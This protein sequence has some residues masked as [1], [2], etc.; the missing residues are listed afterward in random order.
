MVQ[1]R[2]IFAAI[3]VHFC[4]GS[5]IAFVMK[6]VNGPAPSVPSPPVRPVDFY[7]ISERW[8]NRM[9]EQ[10]KTVQLNEEKKIAPWYTHLAQPLAILFWLYAVT[11][12]FIYD[13]DALLE[14]SF[15]FVAWVVKFKF[16]FILGI[17]ALIWSFTKSVEILLWFLYIALYPLILVLWTVPR[18][19]WKQR[20]WNLTFAY[21]NTILSTTKSLKYSVIIFALIIIETVLIIESS[22]PSIL[23]LAVGLSLITVASAFVHRFTLI[24]RPSMLYQVHSNLT[25]WILNFGK[26]TCGV[27]KSIKDLPAETRIQTMS[28]SQRT[29]WAGNLQM[30]VLLNRGCKFFSRKLEDYQRSKLTSVFYALNFL[31]LMAVSVLSS[32]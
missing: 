25:K 26:Q 7:I 9:A 23:W 1:C 8:R 28:I 22:S 4:D 18:F 13:L 5:Y 2:G 32:P 20:S 14:S 15:P 6:K 24:F 31:M 30:A 19:I 17:V 3:V 27:D 29:T 12:I 16:P 10:A 21:V 11:Q